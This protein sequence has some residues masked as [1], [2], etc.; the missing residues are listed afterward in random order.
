MNSTHGTA[1]ERAETG[2]YSVEAGTVSTM[3]HGVWGTAI[4]EYTIC[5]PLVSLNAPW[6]GR[7]MT[8][9]GGVAMSFAAGLVRCD[10]P[11]GAVDEEHT[12]V[13]VRQH[14]VQIQAEWP[15]GDVEGAA[16]HASTERRLEGRRE[17]HD[18]H[19][20]PHGRHDVRHHR[21]ARSRASKLRRF[22][23]EIGTDQVGLVR[24]DRNR[25][26]RR[27]EQHRW[28]EAEHLEE[29]RE[30]HVGHVA[31]RE[32]LLRK[33]PFA[34][35]HV[36]RVRLHE[37]GRSRAAHPEAFFEHMLRVL[38]CRELGRRQSGE[39]HAE[40]CSREHAHRPPARATA[41]PM[42]SV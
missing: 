7:A 42:Q 31:R 40:K 38:L 41:R 35:E 20:L 18:R 9:D 23:G 30:L 8:R 33:C 32:L 1:R 34:P 27:V 28:P 12:A 29:V 22:R 26:A 39:H 24:L 6:L 21:I 3:R 10:Q 4:V 19:A 16:D 36:A 37:S 5:L 13:G 25:T 14:M 11:T 15:R 17:R 2:E